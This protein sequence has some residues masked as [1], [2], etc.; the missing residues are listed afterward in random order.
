[1]CLELPFEDSCIQ[2]QLKKISLAEFIFP[3]NYDKSK[4]GCKHKDFDSP[5]NISEEVK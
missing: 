5:G 2:R 1:M 4:R 3:D